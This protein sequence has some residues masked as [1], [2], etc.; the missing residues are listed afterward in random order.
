MSRRPIVFI[1]GYSANGA[2]FD[3]WM[4]VLQENGYSKDDIHVLTYES[5]SNEITI[6]D[7]AEGFDQALA[8]Q[9]GLDNG[10]EFDAIVHSTGMLVLR[11]WITRSDHRRGRLRH[12][13]ALAPATFG[14]PLAHKA[15]G[16]LGSALK[17]N[18]IE[19]PDFREAG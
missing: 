13:I 14:S 6:D 9:V 4:D 18:R 10:E 15:R 12:L 19:G 7:I 8:G 16:W 17:G 3:A 2:A 11:S 5:L 1:H